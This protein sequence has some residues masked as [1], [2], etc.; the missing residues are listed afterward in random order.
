M[1]NFSKKDGKVYLFYEEPLIGE[2]NRGYDI[3]KIGETKLLTEERIKGLKTGNP[4]QII[5]I[6]EFETK[7]RTLIEKILHRTYRSEKIDGEWFKCKNI[8]E[9]IE[10]IKIEC[11]KADDNINYLNTEIDIDKLINL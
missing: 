1:G 5:S 4:R 6:Y 8:N 10:K 2:E 9:V 7:Y 3:F 11:K